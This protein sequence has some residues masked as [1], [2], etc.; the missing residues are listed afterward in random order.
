[1]PAKSK[2]A[3]ATTTRPQLKSRLGA[4]F[5]QR[6]LA[7]LRAGSIS[8]PEGCRQ[9]GIGRSR[10]YELYS[11]W[12][13]ACAR[14]EAEH[15]SPPVSGGNRR[16]PWPDPVTDLV[17]R[18]LSTEP[19]ASYALIASE[20]HRRCAHTLYRASIRR[21]AQ[22]EGIAR[23][24]RPRGPK[25]DVRRWQRQQTGELWQLDATPHAFFPG[26]P[27]R[28]PLLDM[29]DDCTRLI[30]GA[31]LYEAETLLAYLD[32]LPRAFEKHG[33]PLTLYTDYHSIFFTHQ[34][35]ALTQLGAALKFYDISL[36]YAPTPQAKGKVERLHQLWQSRLPPL[37]AA[38][39]I[40]GV[41][42]ANVL[43]ENLRTHRN[44]AEKHRELGCT[45]QQAWQQ[46]RRQ[47]RSALRPFR[48]DPWWPYVWSLRT[49]VRVADDGTVPL[50]TQR[51]R[52][53]APRAT[54]LVRCQ[55][56][57]GSYTILRSHP[58]KT[59]K[60]EVLLR[61]GPSLSK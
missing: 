60:P 3:K 21:W 14:G 35:D 23:P 47:K 28:Y 33:L 27:Q 54:R 26:D 24:A 58:D 56:P 25:V 10:F 44:E 5:I 13:A 45:P 57:D 15:W 29:L 41:A 16:P 30:T 42:A 34:P 48:R 31:R 12:L 2:V 51:L 43:I 7:L 39:D 50:G 11:A 53:N 37:L 20:V 55:H 22:A 49:T 32:F 61:L 40:T 9:L 17:R 59:R 52:V 8:A 38:D 18:L 6:M 1:M 36:L 46:A 19:P 4:P